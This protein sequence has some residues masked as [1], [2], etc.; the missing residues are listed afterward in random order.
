MSLSTNRTIAPRLRRKRLPP[1][2]H[3]VEKLKA[4]V[5]Q[6]D[7]LGRVADL[8]STEEAEAQKAVY[9]QEVDNAV[10]ILQ[11][12]KP[13]NVLE[14]LLKVRELVGTKS[15]RARSKARSREF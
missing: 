4:K 7:A 2:S 13:D 3:F 11:R 10:E 14:L 15:G 8:R 6:R 9:K 12:S 1:Q 5:S